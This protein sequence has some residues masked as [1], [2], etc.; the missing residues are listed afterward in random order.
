M[1]GQI[2][3]LDISYT[4]ID[5]RDWT[6]QNFDFF[7]KIKFRNQIFFLAKFFADL[8]FWHEA[9]KWCQFC[10]N[11]EFQNKRKNLGKSWKIKDYRRSANYENYNMKH[12]HF[13]TDNQLWVPVEKNENK[14]ITTT[15]FDWGILQLLKSWK[16]EGLK[17][18]K[19]A[20]DITYY[21]F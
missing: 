10:E 11:R 1:E 12:T 6:F 15:V 18:L 4:I 14:H 16:G 21:Q 7:T 9:V 17:K 13:L 5:L 19:K 3:E 8:T 20:M 2:K